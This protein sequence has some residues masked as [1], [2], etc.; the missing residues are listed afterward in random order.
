MSSQVPQAIDKLVAVFSAAL[1]GVQIA[2][3]PLVKFPAKE[4]AAV[5]SDGTVQ[6]EEDAA[7]AVQA[8]SGIGAKKRSE[9]ID[10]VCAIGTSTGTAETSMSARRNRVYALLGAVEDALRADPGLQMFTIDGAAAVTETA[11]KYVTNGQGLAAVVVFTIN[12]PVRS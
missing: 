2:D 7:R 11:L 9:N 1:P 4:W 12:I 3:G 6:T 5:G 8:W 10:V